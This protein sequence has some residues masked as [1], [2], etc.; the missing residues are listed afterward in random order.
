LFYHDI[1]YD[2]KKKN[3]EEKSAKYLEKVLTEIK[4]PSHQILNCITIIKATK[5]H[6]LSRDNDTNLFLD[7]DISIFGKDWEDY[8]IYKDCIRKEYSIRELILLS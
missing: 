6:N 5:T 7:A 2:V 8:L 4:V 1:I 3:N